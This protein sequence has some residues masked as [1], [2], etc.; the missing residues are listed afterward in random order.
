MKRRGG[1][2][3]E[4]QR[5]EPKSLCSG[6]EPGWSQEAEHPLTSPNA[7]IQRG[8]EN[9]MAFSSSMATLPFSAFS[10]S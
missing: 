3:T 1:W 5:K 7:Q 8:V 9:Q 10:S 2:K 6:C 4:M